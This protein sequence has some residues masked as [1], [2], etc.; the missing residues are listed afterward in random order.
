MAARVIGIV[1]GKVEHDGPNIT[2]R[3]QQ[4]LNSARHSYDQDTKIS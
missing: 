1:N 4:M 3:K 2:Y